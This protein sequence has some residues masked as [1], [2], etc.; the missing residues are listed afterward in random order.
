MTKPERFWLSSPGLLLV[1]MAASIGCEPRPAVRP[2]SNEIEPIYD[3]AAGGEERVEVVQPAAVSQCRSPRRS[4]RLFVGFRKAVKADASELTASE[5]PRILSLLEAR[6]CELA[7]KQDPEGS[8]RTALGAGLLLEITALDFTR[9]DAS[10]ADAH[11]QLISTG[12][13]NPD[14]TTGSEA[15]AALIEPPRWV[16]KLVLAK[17]SG[18]RIASAAAK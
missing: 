15:A 5:A 13:A 2:P 3:P 10:R 9:K 17:E 1:W 18:W 6:L 8:L 16:L 12:R 14:G 4:A 11:V 7:P